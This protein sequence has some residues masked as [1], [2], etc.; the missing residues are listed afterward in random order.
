MKVLIAFPFSIYPVTTGGALRGYY[1]LRELV[2]HFEV[3]AVVIDS[4]E[5]VSQLIER[6]LGSAAN[7]LRVTVASPRNFKNNTWKKILNRFNTFKLSGSPRCKSNSTTLAVSDAIEIIA[8]RYPADIAILTTQELAICGSTVKN[9]MPNAIRLMDMHNLDHVLLRQEL[10]SKGLFQNENGRYEKLKRQ[11][12]SLYKY[13]DGAFACSQEDKDALLDLNGRD[14]FVGAVVPNGMDCDPL[15]FDKRAS[16]QKSNNVLFCGT[17]AYLPNIDG[18]NWFHSMIWPLVRLR[19]PNAKL[20]VIG[21]ELDKGKFP[22]L[23]DDDSVELVG[24]VNDIEPYYHN[25]GVAICPLRMG[26]GTRFKIVESMTYGNPMVSTSIG[27]EGIGAQNN[28]QILIRDSEHEFADAIC[29]LM[30]N[31]T[32][33]NQIRESARRF[34]YQSFDWESI[35]NKMAND[36][37]GWVKVLRPVKES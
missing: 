26:S 18:L 6:D 13:A 27:C 21:R 20:I 3:E 1:L 37:M 30:G 14:S 31:E 24:E 10:E 32:R 33:F 2:R 4:V 29:D 35:G 25:A 36:I 16:K 7:L 28:K 5:E 15:V 19:T 22:G 12:S 11:E 17:L 34:V 8:K 23:I 9:K